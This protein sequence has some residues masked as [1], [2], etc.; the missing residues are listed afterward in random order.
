MGTCICICGCTILNAY[1]QTL[2]HKKPILRIKIS[3][4]NYIFNE[5]G[6]KR[7][8]S[9]SNKGL[10]PLLPILQ[11]GVSFIRISVLSPFF[12]IGFSFQFEMF[13]FVCCCF[14]FG[15]SFFDDLTSK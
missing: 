12:M 5:N 13:F 15:R 2:L 3:K 6:K 10:L 11:F 7:E 4:F 9:T 8:K 14:E 1:S